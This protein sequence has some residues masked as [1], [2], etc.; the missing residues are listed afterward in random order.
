MSISGNSWG[1]IDD[2]VNKGCDIGLGRQEEFYACADVSIVTQDG[3][4]NEQSTTS[5]TTPES[6]TSK[7][8]T[9]TIMSTSSILSSIASSST[10]LTSTSLKSTTMNSSP[11]SQTT[12]STVS[13]TTTQS[14]CIAIG[15]YKGDQ[16][17]D[18]WCK[19]NCNGGYC[20]STHC[21]S[22][23]NPT[24]PSGPVTAISTTTVKPTTTTRQTSTSP[25]VITTSPSVITT[26]PSVITTSPSVITTS[27]SVITT[28]SS[29]ITTSSSV[30]TTSPT[31]KQTSTLPSVATT[32][33]STVSYCPSLD[34]YANNPAIV[35]WCRRSCIYNY[36]SLFL[37][38]C[39]TIQTTTIPTT[40]SSTKLLT[41]LTSSSTT[42]AP[43]TNKLVCIGAGAWRNDT[44]M[45]SWCDTNCKLGHCPPS[46]CQCSKDG[47]LQDVSYGLGDKC[48]TVMTNI[49]SNY[50][51]YM[52]L[53]CKHNCPSF[54]CWNIPNICKC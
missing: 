18:K 14:D 20:P 25:S 35:D 31:Q 22:N 29:V 41:T 2:D 49:S 16:N 17:M 45:A 51:M 53:W 39:R 33:Q 1:C 38:K 6:T 26:S 46:T 36:C 40:I 47:S 15:A 32:L 4:V 5:S 23:C 34:R 9:P 28:S 30:K 21:S 10:T 11:P 27:P 52:D 50:K 7:P 37:C 19:V 44:A 12:P 8:S 24:S 42:E 3:G 13:S 43:P 48:Y 54:G